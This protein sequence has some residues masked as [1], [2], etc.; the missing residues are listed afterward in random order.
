MSDQVI[1][2]SGIQ[3]VVKW[4]KSKGYSNIKANVEGYELPTTFTPSNLDV[5][6]FVPDV[7]A[8][9]GEQKHYFEIA[10]K[11]EDSDR[12]IR[13]WKLLS[14][15]AEMKKGKLHLFAPRGHKAFAERIVRERQLAADVV[16]I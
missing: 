2:D 14:T 4:V 8:T 10:L 5:E 6:P 3:R 16:S 12:Q 1:K 7:T 13:K 15:L 11:T 9:R